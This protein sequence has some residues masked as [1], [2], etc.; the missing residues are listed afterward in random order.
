MKRLYSLKKN[1]DFQ[2]TYRVGKS[3][4]CRL[5][6][7]VYV[8][9][10]RKPKKPKN[11]VLQ[12]ETHVRVGFCVSKKVGNSV[13]RNRAKRRLR[14]ALSP[15]LNAISPGHNLIFI[16]RPGVLDEP[17]LSLRQTMLQMLKKAELM[18]AADGR[19]R[20]EEAAKGADLL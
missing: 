11:N 2:F 18:G 16:A 9:D 12:A 15:Y 1:R 20:A 5:F 8:R 7:L 19:A 13:Q 3:V 10:R 4:G 6:T 14:E 17:F